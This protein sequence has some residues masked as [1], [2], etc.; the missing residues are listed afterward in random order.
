MSDIIKIKKLEETCINNIVDFLDLYVWEPKI[1]PVANNDTVYINQNRPLDNN[2]LRDY[3]DCEISKFNDPELMNNFECAIEFI[4]NNFNPS[5]IWLM[6]YP[7]NSK[8]YFHVDLSK[9]RHILSLNENDKFFN[10]EYFYDDE[11]I[12][13]ENENY[14]NVASRLNAQLDE[15]NL[16]LELFNQNFLKLKNTKITKLEKKSVYSFGDTLHTFVNGSNKLRMILVFEI[17]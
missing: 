15:D 3:K 14:T 13:Q 6:T 1:F 10:Y 17:L 9:N 12:I 4:K 2:T 7:P 5:I 8:I 16:N 11:K